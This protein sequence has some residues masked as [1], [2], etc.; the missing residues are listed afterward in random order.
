MKKIP[1]YKEKRS[2]LDCSNYRPISILL[3]NININKIIEKLLYK[4]LTSHNCIYD[5]QYGFRNKHSTSHAL[6]NLTEDIR[7][8][9]DD[10]SSAVSVFIY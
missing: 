2:N 5:L 6:L 8:A 1:T 3:S 7:S 10:N 4:F 9:L